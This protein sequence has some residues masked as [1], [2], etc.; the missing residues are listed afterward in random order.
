M[1]QL[2]S[3]KEAKGEQRLVLRPGGEGRVLYTVLYFTL[4]KASGLYCTLQYSTV[5][6]TVLYEYYQ[7]LYKGA[8]SCTEEL[9]P[10]LRNM[11]RW[12]L[13]LHAFFTAFG[14][15]AFIAACSTGSWSIILMRA[16]EGSIG[17]RWEGRL[18][19]PSKR[20]QIKTKTLTRLKI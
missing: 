13:I 20:D 18:E 9:F 15:Q 12:C 1:V 7:G 6:C 3:H 4:L 19:L 2:A 8:Q 5:H 10:M 16:R 11:A 14:I 17:E